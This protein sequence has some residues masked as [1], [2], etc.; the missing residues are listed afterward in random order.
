MLLMSKDEIAKK[1]N[2][3]ADYLN[4][5]SIF[6]DSFRW[7]AWIMVKG[8]AFF[9]D[10]L[11]KVTDEVLL[12]KQFFQNPEIVAFVD[13][14]RPF[15]YILLAL[16]LLF[17]GY[18]LIFQK[19]F[20]REGIAINLFIAL[21]VVALL[22]TGM[23]K[24]ND[25]TDEAIKAVKTD[26]L[27]QKDDN[28]SL[29]DT[30]IQRN[31]TDLVMFDKNGWS[32]TELDSPND[33]PPSKAKNISIKQRFTKDDMSEV[34]IKL[35]SE[36]DDISKH[37]LVLGE[38]G[39]DKI[40]KFDQSG[41]EWNNEYYYRYDVDWLTLLVT[42]AVMGFT[43]FSIAY[44]LA[45][46][47]FELAFN[48]VLAIIIAPADI[49][50]GQ[51][52]KKVIQSILNT[53]L[54]IILI[55]LSMKIYMIGT[56]YLADQL[57]GMAY[58]I[59]LIA[60]SVAVI[61]GPNI[62]ERLFGIDAGLKSG[63]GVLAG[64]YAGGRMVTGLGKSLASLANKFNNK[65][66]PNSST[67]SGGSGGGGNK[68]P[69]PNDKDNTL[70]P[71]DK[72]NKSRG[73]SEMSSAKEQVAATTEGD[74]EKDGKGRS[75]GSIAQ[76]AEEQNE[77]GNRRNQVKA[78]SPNDTDRATISPV[79]NGSVPSSGGS[80]SVQK[81]QGVQKSSIQT[82]TDI[83]SVADRVQGNS[84]VSNTQ[85]GGSPSNVTERPTS[86]HNG[87]GSIV[88]QNGSQS[89][90]RAQNV[91]KSSVQTD[92]SVTSVADQVQGS[93]FVS[94]VQSSAPIATTT[95][96]TNVQNSNSNAL[97]TSDSHSV[98]KVQGIQKS[99]VQTD[100]EVSNITE[101]VQGRTTTTNTNTVRS[102]GSNSIQNQS[103]ER[104]RPRSYNLDNSSQN[105]IKKMKNFRKK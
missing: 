77:K 13:T 65:N 47:S 62:V 21:A 14:I 78:P 27:Y 103:Y 91:Q 75:G 68:P 39:A 82:D 45:R 15:L 98:Q 18:L 36:S 4:I 94:S 26:H 20:D 76:L 42:L 16:N 50:D 35:S 60:F 19:K 57:D 23:E 53:F 80:H 46:L 71:L 100:V 28:A 66:S 84:S 44:K 7:L 70:N 24:A 5:A 74:Q 83:T 30:I 64:A 40:A 1:I 96:P 102:D 72:E 67:G 87:S 8:I 37:F 55:F 2:E 52:T 79:V 25:F 31:V 59:A 63:W 33:F 73:S 61:D 95:S 32:T 85:I 88:T 93:T 49:H 99:S 17:V 43:L 38:G 11:E 6:S 10:G 58:L 12:I 51:K 97:T 56:V 41:L 69:S 89:V 101:Q 104:K 54:V 3:F 105:T 29:S 90:Q 92:T 34:D 9:V 22:G 86:V 48:Y 81:A